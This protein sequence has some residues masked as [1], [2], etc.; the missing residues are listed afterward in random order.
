ME[1]YN[2]RRGEN[3]DPFSGKRFRGRISVFWCTQ[4]QVPVVRTVS[5]QHLTRSNGWFQQHQSEGRMVLHGRNTDT[6][7]P[8][9]SR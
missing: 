5:Y 3:A 7:Y 4:E 9:S 6:S 8:H 2:L 1:A